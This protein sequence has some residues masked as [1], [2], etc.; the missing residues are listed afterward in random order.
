[1]ALAEQRAAVPAT[2]ARSSAPRSAQENEEEEP[3]VC[4]P[5]HS[6]EEERP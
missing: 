6:P 3:G 5:P 4:H 2:F 1:M